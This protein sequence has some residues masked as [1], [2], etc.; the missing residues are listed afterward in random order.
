MIELVTAIIKDASG[1]IL[2]TEKENDLW[3][4]PGGK[5]EIGETDEEALERK[6]KQD[7]NIEI[8]INNY[9]T[10]KS[11]EK[12]ESVVN[13]IAYD[14]QYEFGKMTQEK[15]YKWINKSELNKYKFVPETKII[16]KELN[17]EME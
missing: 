2:I 3:E 11:F 7:F 16:I 17:K 13:L 8:S 14:A 10:E 12:A 1:K 5:I 15:N 9:I 6:V 4:F